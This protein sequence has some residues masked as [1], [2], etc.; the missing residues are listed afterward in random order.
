MRRSST[1]VEEVEAAVNPQAVFADGHVLLGVDGPLAWLG[2][3]AAG[4]GINLGRHG[5]RRT[6]DSDIGDVVCGCNAD[7]TVAPCG[8]GSAASLEVA[9]AVSGGSD[10]G[11]VCARV[12]VCR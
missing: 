11:E 9:E 7:A 3:E 5:A 2:D 8:G 1:V 12:S 6:S 10:Q 4:L